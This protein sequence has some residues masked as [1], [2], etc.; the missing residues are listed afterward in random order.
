MMDKFIVFGLGNFGRNLAIGLAERG[1]EVVAVD[2]NMHLV[3]NIQDR[4]TYAVR[5]DSTDKKALLDLGLDKFDV[6]I[7]CIGENFEAN[8]LTAV[9]LKQN[10]VKKVI[11]RASDRMQFQILEAVGIDQIIS[12]EEEAAIKLAERLIYKS[13]LEITYIGEKI[14]LAK[15]NAPNEFHGKTIGQLQLRAKYGINVISIH[16]IE[17]NSNNDIQEKEIYNNPGAS[18]VI[19]Q[20]DILVVTGETKN[21][22]KL[23]GYHE[24]S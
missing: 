24:H 20:D 13:L 15:I 22:E 16:R 6:G 2:S 12:P 7:V 18:T 4:V 19:H 17:K 23:I 1:A 5:L 9:L 10:G 3:E 21:L 8:L 14:A 11:S